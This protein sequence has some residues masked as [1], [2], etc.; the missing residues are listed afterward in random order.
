MNQTLLRVLIL[1]VSMSHVFAAKETKKEVKASEFSDES[2]EKMGDDL[3][4][5]FKALETLLGELPEEAQDWQKI[6]PADFQN[7]LKAFKAEHDKLMQLIKKH[8]IEDLVKLASESKHEAF[9]YDMSRAKSAVAKADEA[10]EN[11]DLVSKKLQDDEEYAEWTIRRLANSTINLCFVINDARMA[12]TEK[13]RIEKG[14]PIRRDIFDFRDLLYD[15]L[16]ANRALYPYTYTE[17][18]K[19][20]K[21]IDDEFVAVI[22]GCRKL[23]KALE[24]YNIAFMIA[25]LP[26]TAF[27]VKLREDYERM[28]PELEKAFEALGPIGENDKPRNATLEVK[29]QLLKVAKLALE[30]G[31]IASQAMQDRY[32]QVHGKSAL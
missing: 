3:S 19:D 23:M 21:L 25:E 30:L 2:I 31:Q 14:I 6:T 5:V 15:I 7:K 9:K 13:R 29:K 12:I 1:A 18:A 28:K 8:K 26:D 4:E 17:G 10:I 22:Q 20:I 11:T 32:Q 24:N 27:F 16:T